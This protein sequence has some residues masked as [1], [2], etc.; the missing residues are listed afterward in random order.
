LFDHICSHHLALP[1]ACG[2]VSCGCYMILAQNKRHKFEL[3]R[4]YEQCP[5]FH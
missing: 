1:A 3:L 5:H 4:Y 2:L